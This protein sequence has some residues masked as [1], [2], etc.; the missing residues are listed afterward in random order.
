MSFAGAS[1]YLIRCWSALFSFA[2]GGVPG[3]GSE[4]GETEFVFPVGSPAEDFAMAVAEILRTPERYENLSVGAFH[5][6]ETRLNWV[7]SVCSLVDL[8]HR[9]LEPVS[10]TSEEYV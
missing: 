7:T 1:R 6:Y 10:H 9:A 8:F 2:T 4:R 5:E 3:Y